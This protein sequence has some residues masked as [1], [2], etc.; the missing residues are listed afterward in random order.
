MYVVAR[1][2]ALHV[3]PSSPPFVFRRSDKDDW[4]GNVWEGGRLQRQVGALWMGT[5]T[6]VGGCYREAGLFVG[7]LLFQCILE[8]E[9]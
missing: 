1:A 2:A 6:V 4:T 8:K 5:G 7:E 3:I 9:R